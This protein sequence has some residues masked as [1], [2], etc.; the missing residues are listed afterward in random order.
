MCH[1]QDEHNNARIAD[2]GLSK[3]MVGTDVKAS[4]GTTLWASPEQLQVNL[5]LHAPVT[6]LSRNVVHQERCDLPTR[7]TMHVLYIS[8]VCMCALWAARM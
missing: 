5:D 3:I 1:V 4:P 6:F 2:I 7:G 8:C